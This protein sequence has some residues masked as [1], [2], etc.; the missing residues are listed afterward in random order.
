[1]DTLLDQIITLFSE[2]YAPA[3]NIV[4]ATDF[5]DTEEVYAAIKKLVPETNIKPIDVFEALQNAGYR[6]NAE[7]CKMNFNLK[8]MLIKQF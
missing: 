8:W 2:K 1:M 7:P 5:L 3:S 6:F 4:M